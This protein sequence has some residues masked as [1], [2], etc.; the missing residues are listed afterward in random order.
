[1]SHPFPELSRPQA[2]IFD[3]DGTLVATVKTRIRAWLITFAEAQI[4]AGRGDVAQLIGSDGKYL[5]HEVA[6]RAG[7]PLSDRRA[8]E[9]DRR[10]GEVYSGLN[11]DPRPV[12]GARELLQ[13]LEERRVPWAIATS[14][15]RGQVAVSVK[16]LALSRDAVI[17]DGSHVAHAK[18]DPDLLLEAAQRLG[19]RAPGCWYIGDATWDMLAAK[20][21]KMYAIGVTSGAAGVPALAAA[22]ADLVVGSLAEVADLV[23]PTV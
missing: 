11:T 3:L 10:S 18:P 15:L 16:A 17:V 5:A 23:P 7:R 2:V 22:G 9:I 13:V 14:S 4:P 21:A 12:P 20:R 6:R 19:V 8:A 1:M